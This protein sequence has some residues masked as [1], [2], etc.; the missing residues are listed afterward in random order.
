MTT[1]DTLKQ[2]RPD[3]VDEILRHEDDEMLYVVG[4]DGFASDLQVWT[5]TDKYE[6]L[7]DAAK[8]ASG[9]V[10]GGTFDEAMARLEGAF[11]DSREILSIY[12]SEIR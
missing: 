3:L 2:N 5:E 12:P 4:D 6:I 9:V 11:D 1:I 7:H 8:S 10:G